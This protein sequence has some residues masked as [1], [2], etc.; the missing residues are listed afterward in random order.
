MSID[1]AREPALRLIAE[2]GEISGLQLRELLAS[3]CGI[4]LWPWASDLVALQLAE[5]RLVH[6]RRPDAM[7]PVLFSLSD[8]G[9]RY[10]E[11]GHRAAA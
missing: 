4:R 6:S 5:D 2:A 8:H 3:R 1:D 10:L 7:G 11:A 9:R